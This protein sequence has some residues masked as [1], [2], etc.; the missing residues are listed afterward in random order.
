MIKSLVF[1]LILVLCLNA[2]T[3][4]TPK[5]VENRYLKLS[6]SL[7]NLM[8]DEINEKK[9]A[10]LEKNFEKFYIGMLEYRENNSDLD[11]KYLN[12]YLNETNIKL[13][14]LKDLSD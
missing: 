10:S 13:Q 14:Y 11:T 4:Y 6:N 3:S 1:T 7:D 9:R 5:E 8:S 12:Y 2:C